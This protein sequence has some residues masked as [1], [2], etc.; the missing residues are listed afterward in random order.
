M[1]IVIFLAFVLVCALQSRVT[2]DRISRLERIV[3]SEREEYRRR[4]S[5][6]TIEAAKKIPI[7]DDKPRDKK[8]NYQLPHH[9]RVQLEEARRAVV[10]ARDI[11]RRINLPSRLD[12][13]RRCEHR[14]DVICKRADDYLSQ[15][16]QSLVVLD[17]KTTLYDSRAG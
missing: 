4:I 10:S 14:Y 5:K 13:L 8:P 9:L 3:G 15:Q 7:E 1:D 6:R 11:Y 16:S 2:R 12:E 17:D